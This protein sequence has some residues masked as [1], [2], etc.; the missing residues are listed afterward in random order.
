LNDKRPPDYHGLCK[1]NLEKEITSAND[2]LDF[3][4]ETNN[5]IFKD[6][7]AKIGVTL[8]NGQRL[9]MGDFFSN[10]LELNHD[11]CLY[12]SKIP[13][14]ITAKVDTYVNGEINIVFTENILKTETGLAEKLIKKFEEFSFENQGPTLV[15]KKRLDLK[16][17]G[18]REFDVQASVLFK[19]YFSFSVFSGSPYYVN[20]NDDSRRLSNALAFFGIMYILSSVVRY[21][22]DRMYKLLNEKNTSVTWMLSKICSTAERVYPN[23]MLNL[24]HNKSLKFS[25]RSF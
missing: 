18:N 20:I 19:K 5:G 10:A 21:K 17:L 4:A 24:L 23:L 3:S 22:P 6:L 8:N 12:F 14:F 13:G 15:F 1:E 16:T 7:G 9:S 11:Y 2:L 25:P